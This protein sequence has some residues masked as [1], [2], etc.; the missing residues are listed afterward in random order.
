MDDE[1]L[2]RYRRTPSSAFEDN[3]Y[4]RLERQKGLRLLW[5]EIRSSRA[6]TI[7]SI[8]IVL[9]AIGLMG[10]CA[11]EVFSPGWT[12]VGEYQVYERSRQC[13]DF[14][15]PLS[16]LEPQPDFVNPPPDPNNFL[17][18]D[19]IRE[20]LAYDLQIPTW[21]PDGFVHQFEYTDVVSMM[22]FSSLWLTEE[23]TISFYASPVS[24][25]SSP[26]TADVYRGTAE[27]RAI[28]GNPGIL[29]QG[30]CGFGSTTELEDSVVIE[31]V[32]DDDISLLRW[33]AD[34][35]DYSL[36]SL[37]LGVV[38]AEDLVRMAQSSR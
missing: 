3:L 21:A 15:M 7:L 17:P 6:K 4:R 38:T 22:D 33:R 32:W 20:R 26:L 2:Y 8:F 37:G 34:D 31:R 18:I 12:Q 35:V 14:S 25:E 13:K 19:E 10:A 5:V 9:A 30:G 1:F 16:P 24:K 36:H 23:S 11:R 27:E 28:N 29:V